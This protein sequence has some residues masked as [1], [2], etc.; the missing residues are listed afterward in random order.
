MAALP[1]MQFYVAEYLADTAHLD[2][3]ENGA[4]LLLIF[5]YWQTGK[6]IPKKRLQ[7]VARVSNDRWT[8]VEEALSEFFTD[9]GD[10]WIHDR[11]EADL[12]AVEEAQAQRAAAGKA[13]AEARKAAKRKELKE[14]GN[15]RSTTVQREN[16]DRSTNKE[17]NRTEQNREEK[18]N[19]S[20][21]ADPASKSTSSTK[22]SDEDFE[23][24]WKYCRENWFGKPG[25]KAEA[26]KEFDKLRPEKDDLHEILKLTRQE[27]EHRRRVELA[28]GFCENMKHICRWIKVR[29]WEDVKERL[30]AG[31]S[32]AL[33]GS[34][35]QKQSKVKRIKIFPGHEP[36]L[37]P[38]EWLEDGY[39]CQEVSA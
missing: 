32:L 14:K 24:F 1:Y 15:D 2:A 28:D 17:Q 19:G 18:N 31:P 11:I 4:Y 12:A 26:R 38:G 39:I 37:L 8:D 35:G 7:K 27:C 10:C 21:D 34:A 22:F 6:A 29:G 5:N 16:N 30:E 23:K 33:V 3:E 13:S 9:D 36:Q 20:A 25:H